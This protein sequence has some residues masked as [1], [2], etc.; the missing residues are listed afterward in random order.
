MRNTEIAL[1]YERV[2]MVSY[3]EVRSIQRLSNDQTSRD[4]SRDRGHKAFVHLHIIRTQNSMNYGNLSN[5]GIY[6]PRIYGKWML[7][8]CSAGRSSSNINQLEGSSVENTQHLAGKRQKS[9]HPKH[10]SLGQEV[11]L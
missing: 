5:F 4:Q 6:G 10:F 3:I 11:F 8:S 7:K 1:C 9:F 2:G